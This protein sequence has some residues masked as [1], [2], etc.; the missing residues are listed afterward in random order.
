MV[1]LGS[2][3]INRLDCKDERS[4]SSE[5]LLHIYGFR[6]LLLH[7]PT[8]SKVTERN[9]VYTISIELY[10]NIDTRYGLPCH[11]VA[12]VVHTVHVHTS[13]SQ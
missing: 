5:A 7:V 13:M 11:K 12:C 8:V 10:P 1:H 3:G 2:M 4:K 6:L 9:K